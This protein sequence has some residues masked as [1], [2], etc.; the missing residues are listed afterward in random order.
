MECVANVAVVKAFGRRSA[1]GRD[2]RGGARLRELGDELD[3]RRL[4][5]HGAHLPV[6]G[7]RDG[8]LM[9]I[10]NVAPRP[11]RHIRRASSSWQ[12]CSRPSPPR[13]PRR[14][15]CNYRFIFRPGDDGHRIGTGRRGRRPVENSGEPRM[16]D[17]ELDESHSP[18]RRWARQRGKQASTRSTSCSAGKH[19]RARR[20]LGCGKSTL[21]S[22]I[23]GF[24][25][26]D[27]G[28]ITVGGRDLSNLRKAG[29]EP[30]LHSPAGCFSSSTIEALRRISHHCRPG[31]RT[32]LRRGGLV[33]ASTRF[34]SPAPAGLRDGRRRGG[35][36]LGRRAPAHLDHRVTLKDAP[37]LFSTR[38]RTQS[39]PRTRPLIQEAIDVCPATLRPS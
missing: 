22:L 31:A 6:H 1:D 7:V 4:G 32:R 23:M 34:R 39:T 11:G 19:Q 38:R 8:A 3:E 10:R 2:D 36:Q 21:A 35:V 16:G 30:L 14:R 18:T 25:Q 20:P 12:W 33:G 13:W 17:I 15:P 27:G 37:S 29:V 28:R 5:S 26:P 9:L 24:W